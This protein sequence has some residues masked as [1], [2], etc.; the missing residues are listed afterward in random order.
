MPFS[1]PFILLW[2]GEL[3]L[4]YICN[5]QMAWTSIYVDGN[6]QIDLW[7]QESKG[8]PCP[9]NVN[10][11]QCACCVQDGGCH[12]GK[13]SPNRCTQCGLEKHCSFMCNI[14]IS[15]TDLYKHSG[16]SFGQIKS[17]SLEGPN[18][19][20]YTLVPTSS[21]RVEIQIY[22]LVDVGRFNGSSC[23]GG[24]LQ[25]MN[26]VDPLYSSTDNI[27][28]GVNER[29]SPPV[30]LFSDDGV[31][32]LLFQVTEKTRRSQ[33]LAYFSFTSIN[34]TEG[35]GYQP[36]GGMKLQNTDCDWLYQDFSCAK[37]GSCVIASPN[38][39]GLYPPNRQCKYHITTSSDRMR[40]RITFNALLLPP[41]HCSTDFVAVYHGSTRSS[42]HLLTLCANQRKSVDYPGPKLLLE[43]SSGPQVPPYNH[44]GFVASLEFYEKVSTTEASL[45]QF[46]HTMEQITNYVFNSTPSSH[47]F[48]CE[49]V[50][51]GNNTRSGHFDTREY[52]W[53]PTCRLIFKGRS[54]DV[55][56][57]SLFN[58][59]LRSPLCRSVIE[60]F[61][62]FMEDTKGPI[63]KLC[64][65]LLRQVHDSDGSSLHVKKYLST[66]NVMVIL[67][68]RPTAP[69]STND[70]E[71]ISGSF[72]FHDEQIS[73]TMQPTG[74]CDV[75]Y[76]GMYS[77]LAGLLDN[78]GLQ[79]LYWNI[80]G[81]LK[82]TQQFLPADNQSIVLKILGLEHM[83]QNPTC[84]TQC[85][86]NGCRCVSKA[87]LQNIDHFMIVNEEGWTV[88]C[89]CGAFQQEW[90]PVSVRSWNLLTVVYSVAHYVWS[91]KGF[92]FSASY[93]FNTDTICSDQIY[94]LHSGEIALK[95]LTSPDNLNHFYYQ[96]CTWTL[97][98]NVERQLELDISSK[99]N[100]PC[101][102]WN[103]S[104]HEYAASAKD[105]HLGE[106]LHTFCS[107]D[108]HK[109]YLLPWKLNTIIIRLRTLS[110]TL[111]Q[112]RI[113][114]KSQVIRP[115]T[116]FGTPTASPNAVSSM[117]CATANSIALLVTVLGLCSMNS[118]PPS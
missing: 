2:L 57:I 85:G 37:L 109:Q 103:I 61:D 114:W 10:S 100:R 49:I 3:C 92:E 6:S 79:Q 12:C 83:A 19:C 67:L 44:N 91:N 17:P 47:Q 11:N 110:R 26:G 16:K 46:S 60:I 23:V 116:R 81:P 94:T 24:Y 118:M 36:K 115:N 84:V 76:N 31:A 72:F 45:P 56:H 98:S 39:P 65:P 82:C 52:E 14:S 20:W 117:S 41:N 15:S 113:K 86:D 4:F 93:S 21:E 43:F 5:A 40:V 106:L 73:G 77:P 27:V 69:L 89:L 53:L 112:F 64:S 28:C 8:C 105:R 50:I 97:H 88:A 30:V 108:T 96:T 38:Y 34:N 75:K 54:T 25:L 87:A 9:W 111:P 95:N 35:V 102:A 58:Y 63:D 7:T 78:P 101:T 13:E 71:F 29:F 80:D 33:F 104:I 48:K 59:R 90:F 1:Q 99:Q 51:S 74:L 32:S 55:I 62:G 68:R 42:P 70:A 107:R 66:K 18:H 22:R